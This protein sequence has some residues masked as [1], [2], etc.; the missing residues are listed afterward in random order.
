MNTP[1]SFIW[2]INLFDKAFKYGGGV[3][4]WGYVGTNAEP[5]CVQLCNFVEYYILVNYLTF[6][7]SFCVPP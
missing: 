2:I 3:K 7:L 1:T 4:C 6:C 5:L